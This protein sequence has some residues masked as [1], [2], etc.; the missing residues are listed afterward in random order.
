MLMY[1]LTRVFTAHIQT[2]HVDG[3]I[4]SAPLNCGMFMLRTKKVGLLERIEPVSSIRYKLTCAY[5]E[6]S[7]GSA[8]S[9]SDQSLNFLHEEILDPWL[10]MED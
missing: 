7:N 4:H 9:Q 2:I 10:P 6:Y 1:R 5:S 8:H 3:I